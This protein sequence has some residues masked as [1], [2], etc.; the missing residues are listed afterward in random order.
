MLLNSINMFGQIEEESIKIEKP[1]TI[2][3]DTTA[4]IYNGELNL[5]DYLRKTAF[6]SNSLAVYKSLIG[7]KIFNLENEHYYTVT[8][9]VSSYNSTWEDKY[10]HEHD[11]KRYILGAESKDDNLKICDSY[12]EATSKNYTYTDDIIAVKWYN[13]L[14]KTWL[15]RK[16]VYMKERPY[17]YDEPETNFYINSETMKTYK[18]WSIIDFVIK[19]K[20]LYIKVSRADKTELVCYKDCSLGETNCFN[21]YNKTVIMD[22]D[23]AIRYAPKLDNKADSAAAQY[24]VTDLLS[25]GSLERVGIFNHI[26]YKGMSL[27]YFNKN[28][29]TKKLIEK[30]NEE[31]GKIYDVYKV[32]KYKVIFCNGICICI[33]TK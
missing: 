8:G 3:I 4:V 20:Q 25:Y 29:K 13:F 28:I 31:K 22:F 30:S 21:S 16:V 18:P 15:N 5:G 11:Y 32:G 10:F 17:T 7:E 23:Y 1:D 33:S 2:K 9:I 24:F 6:Y 12:D 14:K 27:G 19:D 26:I